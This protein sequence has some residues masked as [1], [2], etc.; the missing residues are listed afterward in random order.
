MPLI[1][2][3]PECG[4]RV[5]LTVSKGTIEKYVVLTDDVVKNY[6]QSDYI[7]QRMDLVKKEI[8]SVF[9]NDKVKQFSLSDFA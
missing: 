8:A 1:G 3:C 4:G 9:E 2:K 5:I 6:I 7:K